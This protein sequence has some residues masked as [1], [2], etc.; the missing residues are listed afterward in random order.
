MILSNGDN[1]HRIFLA[2]HSLVNE[3]NT[4]AKLLN[5]CWV[6]VGFELQLKADCSVLYKAVYKEQH[7]TSNNEKPERKADL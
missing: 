3:R 2:A 5:K 7:M 6:H 1:T 4:S